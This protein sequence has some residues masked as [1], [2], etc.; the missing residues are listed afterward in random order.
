MIS[1]RRPVTTEGLDISQSLNFY[2]R[3][4]F[5]LHLLPL[6][7]TAPSPRVISVFAGGM[8]FS[9][10]F[11]LNTSDL[12][13]DRAGPWG[14]MLSQA[15]MG[16]MNTL[17][18]DHISRLPGNENVT[19]IH[20]HPGFVRTGNVYRGF[21]P[22]SW[23]PWIASLTLD[24]MMM[25]LGFSREESAERYLYQI[26]SSDFGTVSG[27]GIDGDRQ[28]VRHGGER[29]MNT[30][31][32]RKG[33]LWLVGK[34]CDVVNHGEKLVTL[35]DENGEKVWENVQGWLGDCYDF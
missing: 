10:P 17:T 15:H 33:G 19:F 12:N 11:P 4:L 25:L 29:G 30:M 34:N 27:G 18:L 24:P 13:L 20:S 9:F 5:T 14:F 35:R 2:T 26:T 22:G 7:R 1:D 28:V 31:G 16:I 3:I 21:A 8:E 32:G 6:L 23:G